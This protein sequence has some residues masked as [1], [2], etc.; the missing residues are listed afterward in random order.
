[1]KSPMP[2]LFPQQCGAPQL[3]RAGQAA[4]PDEATWADGTLRFFVNFD[5]PQD[6]HDGF[7]SP[8]TR[9]SK[10]WPHAAQVY[11]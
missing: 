7:S 9:N 10:S 1:M 3:S 6:G 8:R 2:Q 4:G 5:C 11:S